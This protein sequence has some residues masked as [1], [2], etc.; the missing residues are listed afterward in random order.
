MTKKNKFKLKLKDQITI[1]I[2]N[3][4]TAEWAINRARG[5]LEE[6]QKTLEYIKEKLEKLRNQYDKTKK[7]VT[8]KAEKK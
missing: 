1:L 5:D 6:A 2:S 4:E 7:H 3:L 8:K